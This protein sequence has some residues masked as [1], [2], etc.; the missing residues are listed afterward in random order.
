MSEDSPTS[1]ASLSAELRARFAADIAAG[2]TIALP[3][4]ELARAEVR[5][6]LPHLLESLEQPASN[7]LRLQIPN[8]TILGEI[9]HGGMSTVYLASHNKLS[10]YVALKIVPNWLGGQDR[11]RERMLKEAQA[12]ARLVHPNIVTIHDIIDTGDTVAIAMEWVDGLTLAS[13]LRTL[14]DRPAP[15]DM[16][17]LRTSLGTPPNTPN[18]LESTTTRTFVRM[19]AEVARAVHCVHQ[20]GL[21]HLDIKPSNVLVRRNGTPL[22]ADF[23]VVR[24]ID[25][26]MTHT[27]SFAGTPIY[28]APEQLR[29]DDRAFGPRTDVYGLGITLYELL[30][31]AQPL[32]HEGLTKVLQDIQ[33]GRIPALSSRAEV[34]SDLENIVHKAISPETGNRYESAQ[35]F[36]DDLQRF[37]EGRPVVARPLSRPARLARWTRAEPWK[38]LLAAILLITIPLLALLGGKLLRDLPVTE[39]ANKQAMKLRHNNSV[40]VGFQ[41]YLVSTSIADSHLENLRV[42]TEEDPSNQDVLAC[43]LTLESAAAPT[44]ATQRITNLGIRQTLGTGLLQQRIKENRP[45]FDAREIQLLRESPARLDTLL[46][47]MDQ[48]LMGDRSGLFD[49]LHDLT[50]DIERAMVGPDPLLHGARIWL[51]ARTGNE[52]VLTQSIYFVTMTWPDDFLVNAW[53]IVALTKIDPPRARELAENFLKRNPAHKGAIVLIARTYLNCGEY[54]KA[55]DALDRPCK[56]DERWDGVARFLRAKLLA[57]LGRFE[58]AKTELPL[59]SKPLEESQ[60]ALQVIGILDPP[61]AKAAYQRLLAREEVSLNALFRAMEFA[62]AN[63]DTPLLTSIALRG[64]ALFPMQDEFRWGLAQVYAADKN[65]EAAAGYVGDRIPSQQAIAYYGLYAATLRLHK[66]DWNGL[67]QL[68]DAWDHAEPDS[69]AS[70]YYRGLAMNRL[71]RHAAAIEQLN[72]HLKLANQANL[73]KPKERPHHYLEAYFELAWADSATQKTGAQ[74]RNTE[75]GERCRQ[76]FKKAAPRANHSAWFSL[77]AAERAAEDGDRPAA[78]KLARQAKDLLGKHDLGAPADLPQLIDDAIERFQ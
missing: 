39:A 58:E 70:A 55:L 61:T 16:I 34:P 5:E 38:A 3:A 28:A 1:D 13:L 29:R 54:Q 6:Q 48:L 73:A 66:K 62:Q 52:K 33:A 47:I 63:R 40:H 32:R 65:Y 24:E 14:P 27:H 7:G 49:S 20:N 30:A 36:A 43:L 2:R 60:E 76:L 45:F 59:S 4:S 37:L 26:A 46:M 35:A 50:E 56:P 8:Y 21:L 68:C 11:A 44:I 9:G 42:A 22:L 10:R 74:P 72:R 78:L 25:L 57:L 18:L 19:M 69:Y 41:A 23:G 15:E 51:A 64:R 75:Q 53:P 67:I 17:V 71:G 12:M 77:I 31:R